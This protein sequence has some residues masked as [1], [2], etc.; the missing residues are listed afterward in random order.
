M[1]PV[2]ANAKRSQVVCLPF[3]KK[4]GLPIKM[5][6]A[7]FLHVQASSPSICPTASLPSSHPIDSVAGIFIKVTPTVS[8]G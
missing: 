3:I 4:T 8:R 1:P 6:R 5:A 2:P 7:A